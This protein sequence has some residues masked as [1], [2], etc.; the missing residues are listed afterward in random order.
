M[1]LT[2]SLF[3]AAM[4][5]TGTLAAA[6]L[7]S[8]G[9]ALAAPGH[10]DAPGAPGAA[11]TLRPGDEDT[12][13]Q[14][15]LRDGWDPDEPG[16]SPATVSGGSF[17]KLFDT[18]VTGQV[19][20]QPLVVDNTKAGTSSVIVATEENWVYSLDGETGAINWSL[21]LGPYWLSS[22]TNCT[23]LVP[24][25]G[26]T[27]TPV[28][29]PSDGT[30]YVTAVVND[31]PTQYQPDIYL[32]AISEQTG[33]VQWKVPIQ[34]S[35]VNDPDR[36][37]NPLTERQRASLLLLNGSVYMA[38]GS[39]CDY[40]PYAGYVVGVNTT[41]R[42]QTMWTDEAGLTDD[43]SGIWM[44]G[45]GLMSDGSGRIFVVTGNGVS[46]AAGPGTSPPAELGDSVVRLA[47]T[48]GGALAAQ[49]FFSPA[50]AP[51]LDVNDTDFG[52]GGA[53]GLPFGTSTYPDLMVAAGKDG[54]V[55]LLDR[56]ALGGRETGAGGTDNPVSESGPYGGEWGRPAAFAGDGGADYVY[57]V[58]LA[59]NLRA[60]QFNAT[61]PAAPTLTDVANSTGTFGYTSGSPAVTSNGTDPASAVVWEVYAPNESGAGGMLEAFDAVP[62][63]GQMQEIWS[64]PI[65]TASKFSVPATADGRVY[66]G[67]R[68]GA[69]LGFG[70]PDT[71]PVTAPATA[72]GQVAVGASASATV[73]VT[74]TASVT[75]TGVGVAGSGTPFTAKGPTGKVTLNAGQTLSIPVTFKPVQPGGFTGSLAITTTTPNFTTVTASL[76]GDGTK[77]GLYA[78]KTGLA[79]GTVPTGSNRPLQTDI[80]NGGTSAEKVTAIT[81]ATAPF[82]ITGLA[83]NTSIPAGGS[84]VVTV[85]FKPAKAGAVTG[86]L[87]VTGSGQGTI[88][89]VTLTATGVNGQGVLAAPASVAFG[90]LH[91][92]QFASQTVTLK[93]TGN[94]PVTITRFSAPAVPFGTP[95]PVTTGLS[96]APGYS[97]Q[98]PVT[99]TPQSRGAAGGQ[100]QITY[101]D[102][103]TGAR[104]IAIPVS[105][106]GTAPVSGVAIPS[107]GGGWTL[108]GSA[109][110]TGTTLQLTPAAQNLAGSAV[111][112][113][114]L[115]SNG[116]TAQFTA[117]S[118]GGTGADGMTFALLNP[119]AAS[120]TSVGGHGGMLG[121]GG[122]SGVAVVLG[123]FKDAGDPAGNFIGIATGASNGHLVFAATSTQVP[124]LRTGTHKIGVTVSGGRISVW[125]DVKRYL[126][127][128]VKLPAFVLPAFTAG[129]GV[130]DDIHAVTGVQV[131]S[132]PAVVPPPGGGWSYNGSALMYGSGTQLTQR[133]ANQAG[134]VVYQRP[135]TSNGLHARFSI[136]IGGGSGGEGMTFALLTPPAQVTALGADGQG[137]GLSGLTGV[138]VAFN[139]FYQAGNPSANFAAIVTGANGALTYQQTAVEIGQLR[140][141]THDVS[142]TVQNGVLIVD[143]DGQQVLALAVSLPP[144]VA[145]AYTAGTD[146]GTDIHLVRNAAIS[147]TS[148][149]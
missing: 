135:V 124:D 100:Y 107:P 87:T 76:T 41:T 24:D 17:G 98:M 28:Y 94:L 32:Y 92:G 112:Y 118:S 74:A 82:G 26:V 66:V 108:N 148:F 46:P 35:P 62:Q 138:A 51:T 136:L 111:Y 137:L 6:Q 54:R 91:L 68:D 143:L 43:Q 47:V 125:V 142:V 133:V 39:Y 19:Y 7:A 105:G 65:G 59:D 4:L 55:F 126:T 73:T 96:V 61:N 134:S 131:S 12:A 52:S 2:A 83:K 1:R 18:P 89:A 33:A 14:N 129:T 99:F 147:A 29:D 16:L 85:T 48:Q 120:V 60:L 115:A 5:L 53:V 122:V 103:Q 149:G 78:S 88:A 50:S 139:T 23:D 70:S 56:D 71:A 15:L 90:N 72:F 34:G 114:P 25:V 20:A 113:Q 130:G 42:A 146:T 22:V 79:F 110:M 117:Q 93:N 106:T 144:S 116:L 57:Y 21:N 80:V 140:Q 104:T 45:S 123:T 77:T 31:G 37:F 11:A 109:Q 95:T 102:G 86:K 10:P 121:F 8:P 63:G 13:S 9:A 145:L 58:G 49:D 132:G 38:F 36:P 69:V 40:S 67:T 141:G 119:A 64:A 30:L 97:I 81:G 84:V 44:G 127:V 27:S 101:S 75:I 3:T 128:A